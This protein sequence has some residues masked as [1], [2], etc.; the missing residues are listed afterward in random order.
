M[1][2]QASSRLHDGSDRNLQGKAFE[3]NG[4]PELSACW[5]GRCWLEISFCCLVVDVD[6]AGVME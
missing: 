3:A 1:R 2:K 5:G 6:V 4:F